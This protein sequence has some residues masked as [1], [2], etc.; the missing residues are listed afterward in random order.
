ML[1][2]ASRPT[3]QRRFVPAGADGYQGRGMAIADV[4]R[5]IFAPGATG[6]PGLLTTKWARPR[7]PS[8]YVG[9][10]R[11][12]Q[13]LDEGTAGLVTVVSAGAGWGKTLA[14]AAWAATSPSVGPVAWL[15]LDETDNHAPLF[16]AYVVAALRRA[17]EVPPGN[18]LAGLSPGLGDEGENLRRLVAGIASLP[19]PVVLV[20]D[21]FQVIRDSALLS[22]LADLL[23]RAPAQLRLVILTRADPAL[24]LNRLRVAGDL[25]EIR[26]RDLAFGPAE[27]VSLLA[28]DG[29]MVDAADAEL[30]VGR[31][32]GWPAGL[33]LAAFFLGQ[34]PGRTAADFAGDDQA[35][36][37]YLLEE[38]FASQPPELRRFLARTSVAQ[39]LSSDL[40]QVLTDEPRAQRFLE[41]LERSNAFV[42]GLGTDRPLVPVPPAAPGGP[43]PSADDRRAASSSPSC[44]VPLHSGSR[45]TGIPSRRCGTPLT[46]RT[47]GCWVDCSSRMPR[48]DW[49]PP[50][51]PHCTR[52]LAR[53]P[54]ERLSDGPELALC[55]AASTSVT[56]AVSTTCSRIST[57]PRRG[58]AC[59]SVES[60]SGVFVALRLL[61]TAVARTHGD[62][63]GLVSAASAA[64]AEL[65]GPGAAV[66]AV[67]EYR[68]V[69]LGNL[70][71]GLL[72]SGHLG[73]AEARLLEGFDVATVA[74]PGRLSDQHAGAP[75][76]GRHLLGEVAAGLRVRL[77]GGR[78]GGV[79][80]LG[81]DRP[82]CHRVPGAVDG[83]S[84]VERRGRG[85]DACSGKA[86][87]PRS[88]TVRRATHSA[89]PRSGWTPPWAG[90]R[91]PARAW[92]S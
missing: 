49:C 4:E 15:S 68:A 3:R 46:P 54:A 78:A 62:V 8:T 80:R 89:W 34:G 42:L 56:L 13:M 85:A 63:D 67:E 59:V 23:R 1:G 88:R 25:A 16:W 29:V 12:I 61:S 77:Q 86:G 47:G 9:R 39:R 66:P 31:T 81:A 90:R 53:I 60:R 73:E 52:V 71:T 74:G 33:R 58:F 51:V 18:P 91:R 41:T 22:S 84:P 19:T 38:V 64:L 11:I 21:D 87:E 76:A 27:A 37:D 65:S 32:E 55:A 26:S 43:A 45:R 35:V 70:G 17:V 72:W 7:I 57:A 50:I 48:R 69:A 28:L 40:A 6:D 10:P 36:T 24:P 92:P 14:T 30:L 44:T 20:L 79:P 2:A 82:G 83:S 75:R 5:P